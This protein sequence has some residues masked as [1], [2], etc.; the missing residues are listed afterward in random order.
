MSGSVSS[1]MVVVAA[2]LVSASSIIPPR[3]GLWFY[4]TSEISESKFSTLARAGDPSIPV[5][6]M[7]LTR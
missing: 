3:G 4:V 2:G 6:A 5:A 1:L 7:S